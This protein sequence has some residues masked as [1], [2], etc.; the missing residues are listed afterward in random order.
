MSRK[1]QRQRQQQAIANQVL[2]LQNK[3][4]EKDLALLENDAAFA[5]QIFHLKK[6]LTEREQ[7]GSTMLSDLKMSFTLSFV[8]LR[9]RR[10]GRS[11]ISLDG[12]CDTLFRFIKQFVFLPGDCL[13]A[14]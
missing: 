8:P 2:A 6:L 4:N 1:Q 9:Q 12:G 5:K 11:S 7:V 13:S 14:S 10:I 3:V